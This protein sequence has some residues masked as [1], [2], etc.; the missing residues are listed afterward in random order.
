[1]GFCFVVAINKHNVYKNT[2]SMDS[3]KKRMAHGGLNRMKN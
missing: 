1:M 3:L 2:K